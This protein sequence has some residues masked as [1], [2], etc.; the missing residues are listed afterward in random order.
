M[1]EEGR[2]AMNWFDEQ[3]RER[4][5]HDDE[6][7]SEA[8]AALAEVVM[9]ERLSKKLDDNRIR[10]QNAID[11]ILK[12]YHVKP[13]ELPD[14]IKDLNDQL[15]YLTRP[16]GIMRRSVELK[17]GWY[18]DAIGAMLGVRK[19]D[20]TAVA[21]IPGKVSGYT[22]YDFQS[23]RRRRVNGETAKLIDEEAISF[24][25]PL[26]SK[27]LGIW[28]LLLY[29]VQ[30]LSVTD[31][32][33]VVVAAFAVSIVGI[34]VPKINNI[35]YEYV[36]P[37]E[38]MQLF[39]AA[40]IFLISVSFSKLL[41][42]TV[43]NL[44][45]AKLTNKM[46]IQVQA[47]SMMRL[48]SLPANFFQS[49]SA[50]ELATRLNYISSLSSMLSSTVLGAGLTFIASLVYIAQMAKYG[51]GLVVPGLVLILFSVVFSAAAVLLQI[52]IDKKRMEIDAK[53]SGLEYMLLSGIQKIKLAGAEKRAFSKWAMLYRDSAKLT[54]DPPALIKLSGVISSTISLVGTIVIYYF[55]ITTQ[56]ALADYYAFNTAY[57][58]VMGAFTALVGTVSV[59]AQIKPVLDMTRPM[60]QTVPEV[61][62]SKKVVTDLSGEIELNNVSFRYNENAPLVVDN[63]SLKIHPGQYVA[64]VG[65][66][67]CGKSTLMRLLLGFESPRKGAIYYDG[68][69]IATLDLKSLRRH[70]GSVIQHGKLFQG[71]IFSN[72]VISAPWLTM[73][74]AWEAAE[75][76]GIADD[77]R[78]MPM[79]MHTVISEG[80][81]GV[82]GGQRQRL[83]IARAI[84]PKPRILMFDEATSALDNITQKKVS[85]ALAGLKCT[86]IVIAHRLSTI[87]QCDRVIMLSGGKIIEDGTYDELIALGGEFARLVERQQI[88]TQ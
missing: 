66:S 5:Q 60:L 30:T 17:E 62:E 28:D 10:T 3:I 27:K 58:M 41:L 40:F 34:F 53:A 78:H 11:E 23:G 15:E 9:G 49:F 46:S 21:L 79:E 32:L 77:I 68:Q 72:I 22:F 71:D 12:F 18:K 43:K 73:Q 47:A 26:P 75:M 69:D 85:D 33:Q 44:I 36:I 55:T 45:T 25:K 57:G 42:G 84:A 64:I 7:F 2:A 6:A 31:F 88:E 74:D 59:I 14:E 29:M 86:R 20:N 67:G 70:I 35:I 50:N 81:G 54:Y 37:G 87:R 38:K 82:S 83:L 63:L 56:V 52:R 13:Q 80:S 39:L 51:P 76:A 1:S 19:D 61:S 24:Y 16:F 65:K 8:F 48:L 4:I